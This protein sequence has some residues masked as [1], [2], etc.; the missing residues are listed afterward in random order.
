MG[1]K[2]YLLLLNRR[3]E[4]QLPLVTRAR[5]PYTVKDTTWPKGETNGKGSDSAAGSVLP[6]EEWRAC[7]EERFRNLRAVRLYYSSA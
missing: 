5:N 7:F 1:L 6:S 2:V 3:Q 4:R